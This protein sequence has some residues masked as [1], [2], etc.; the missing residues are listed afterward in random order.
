M[1]LLLLLG[2]LLV[3]LLLLGGDLLLLLLVFLVLLC[4]PGVG[5][6]LRLMR[7]NV[8]GMNRSWGRC[9]RLVGRRDIGLTRRGVR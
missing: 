6:R 1:V 7:S 5:R 4:V 9:I 2:K 8:L 3:F